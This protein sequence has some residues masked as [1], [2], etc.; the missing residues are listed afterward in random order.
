MKR[1]FLATVAAIGFAGSAVAAD[2]PARMYKAAPPPP[3]AC[4]QF[5]GFYV[6]GNV[7]W[8]YY[9]FDWHDRDAWAQEV[10][11]D[12]DL[13]SSTRTNN[14]G[15]IGGVQ[16]GFNLQTRCTVFGVE[17]DYGWAGITASAFHTDGAA[18]F[19]E[20]LDVS[21]ELRGFGTLRTRAGVVVDS[22]LIYVTGGL[23]FGDFRRSWTLSQNAGDTVETFHHSGT[24]WGWTA[25]FGT[26]W[27]MWGNWSLKSEVLY[28][29]FEKDEQT[30]TSAFF[31][32]GDSK[33]FESH[34]SVWVTRIGLNYRFGDFG[35]GPFG[36]GPVVAKY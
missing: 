28:A 22:V 4:A 1:V 19:D 36:K 16:G 29:R 34:D 15:F 23:A 8:A 17:A 26:E 14:N 11:S 5:G 31:D 13:P 24:R 9:D 32:E 20:S 3:P 27:A 30:F 33:R 18:P 25:G 6:G 7:G 35:I 10:D 21:S 12:N 2:L